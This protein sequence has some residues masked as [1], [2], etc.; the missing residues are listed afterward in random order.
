MVYVTVKR[1]GKCGAFRIDN[2]STEGIRIIIPIEYDDYE[3]DYDENGAYIYFIEYN[4]KE[5][6][7]LVLCSDREKEVR[8]IIEIQKTA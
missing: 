2:N 7:K 6:V 3:T 1:N 4:K 5:K 8:D